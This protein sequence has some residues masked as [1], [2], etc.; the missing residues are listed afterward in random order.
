MFVFIDPALRQT[1]NTHFY[2][3]ISA[4]SVERTS[5]IKAISA[6]INRVKQYSHLKNRRVRKEPVHDLQQCYNPSLFSLILMN[7]RTDGCSGCKGTNFWKQ[8]I[9]RCHNYV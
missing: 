7:K 1:M 4:L 2:C 3:N 9:F 6:L 8:M 5:A